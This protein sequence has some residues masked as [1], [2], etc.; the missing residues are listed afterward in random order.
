MLFR[1][2]RVGENG[3]LFTLYKFRSMIALTPEG[4][5]ETT[6]AQWAQDHDE[7]ITRIGHLIRKTRIDELPQL[8]N[9]LKGELSFV[10]PR[11][12]RPEFVEQLKAEI[13]FYDVRH[14]VR[15]GLS[16]WAQIN[17]P[18]GASVKDAVEKLQ[19]DLYYIKNRSLVLDVV[20]ALKTL[21]VMASGAGK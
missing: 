6:G 5:A 11:P 12:E 8:W 19:Y 1:S 4:L 17:F 21:L 20:I 7:R 9:V 3:K 14:L 18:Y 2:T 15:P 13:P 10:G 16:G